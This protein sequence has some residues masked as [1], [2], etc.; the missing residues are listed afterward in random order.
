[1]GVSSSSN[2]SSGASGSGNSGTPGPSGRE[3]A[4]EAL[5]DRE[6]EGCFY[7]ASRIVVSMKYYHLFF[8]LPATG[9]TDMV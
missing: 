7:R 1:M 4:I 5:I 2:S 3:R 8:D 6:S 9:K